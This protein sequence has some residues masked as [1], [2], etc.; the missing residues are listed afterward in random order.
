MANLES[1]FNLLGI[2]EFYTNPPGYFVELPKIY[3]KLTLGN[4]EFASSKINDDTIIIN[5]CEKKIHNNNTNNR[6]KFIYNFRLDDS[7]GQTYNY[8]KSVMLKCIQVMK[9]AESNNYPV[10]INCA[11][12]V[13]R[14]CSAI[15]AYAMSNGL[16]VNETINYI[17]SKKKNKYGNKWP[18]L[19]N[20]QFVEY[21][22]Q[23]QNEI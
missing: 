5:L 8:F 20:M 22:H 10:I 6:N 4:F 16:S 23:M 15:V 7:Y 12:G 1:A 3:K 17:K 14:S 2:H 21:L 18:T 19:T 11:A 13:N 9:L